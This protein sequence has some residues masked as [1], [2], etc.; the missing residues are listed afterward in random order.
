[1]PLSAAGK[2]AFLQLSQRLYQIAAST[3]N[4]ATSINTYTAFDISR[5]VSRVLSRW[6]V[7]RHP[8]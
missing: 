3:E 6:A 1:M 2:N 5:P 8:G 4:A 7:A